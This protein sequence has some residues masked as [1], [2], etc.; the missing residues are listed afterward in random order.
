MSIQYKIQSTLF[1]MF[2]PIVLFD[3]SSSMFRKNIAVF[4]HQIDFQGNGPVGL[5]YA[6]NDMLHVLQ[7]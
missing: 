5:D 3:K 2:N 6:G 4:A 1:K 7:A